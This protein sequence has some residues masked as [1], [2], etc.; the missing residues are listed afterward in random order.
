MVFSQT[1]LV[2]VSHTGDASVDSPFIYFFMRFRMMRTKHS[3]DDAQ[4]S[5]PQRKAGTKTATVWETAKSL[6][7]PEEKEFVL[8]RFTTKY[9]SPALFSLNVSLNCRQSDISVESQLTFLLEE[10]TKKGS[11][12]LVFESQSYPLL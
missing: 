8:Q 4:S 12:F 10:R 2:D 5:D 1:L 9:Y 11:S 6:A 7:A 3:G